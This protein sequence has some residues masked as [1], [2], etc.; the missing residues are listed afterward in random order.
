MIHKDQ[1]RRFFF[2]PPH[3]RNS[4]RTSEIIISYI[5]NIMKRQKPTIF[6]S[7]A[8]AGDKFLS[9]MESSS[10]SGSDNDEF[11]DCSAAIDAQ[12]MTNKRLDSVFALSN[13]FHS[14]ISPFGRN[15]QRTISAAESESLT[16]DLLQRDLDVYDADV[17]AFCQKYLAAHRGEHSKM[18][19][20]HAKLDQERIYSVPEFRPR[21]NLILTL[22]QKTALGRIVTAVEGVVV[23]ISIISVILE[24]FPQYSSDVVPSYQNAWVALEVAITTFFVL[25]TAFR[26]YVATSVKSV[27]KSF[28]NWC[29]VLSIL[30]LFVQLVAQ[31]RT[32]GWLK[33]LRMFRLVK[34]LRVF[35]YVDALAETLNRIAVSLIAPFVLL[36]VFIVVFGN[37][38][39]WVE[40]GSLFTDSALTDYLNTTNLSTA[41]TA[42]VMSLRNWAVQEDCL[43]TGTTAALFGNLT[44]LPVASKFISA[45]QGMWYATASFTTVGYGDITPLCAPG[46]AVT[47]LAMLFSTVFIAMPIAI[48][49]SSFTETVVDH[50]RKIMLNKRLKARN[51]RDLRRVAEERSAEALA[52][53]DGNGKGGKLK[54]YL[55]QSMTEK[56][57]ASA[58]DEQKQVS[59]A[60]AL[61]RFIAS[62]L[63]TEKLDFDASELEAAK[64]SGGDGGTLSGKCDDDDVL[65]SYA[66]STVDGGD[67]VTGVPTLTFSK[68]PLACR[69]RTELVDVADSFLAW[70]FEHW[71]H[72]WLAQGEETFHAAHSSN[73]F[74]A[75]SYDISSINPA[76]DF[77][78][79]VKKQQEMEELRSLRNDVRTKL[80]KLGSLHPITL[81]HANPR[82]PGVVKDAA[83]RTRCTTPVVGQSSNNLGDAKDFRWEPKSEKPVGAEDCGT[84]TLVLQSD[85]LW[86]PDT[87]GRFEL[88]NAFMTKKIYFTPHVSCVNHIEI[89]GTPLTE[90]AARQLLLEQAALT[91]I[92]SPATAP[93]MVVAHEAPIGNDS[94]SMH[95][96]TSPPSHEVKSAEDR[97]HQ[98]IAQKMQRI[99]AVADASTA[100]LTGAFYMNSCAGNI[101]GLAEWGPYN[102][103]GT[104][105]SSSTTVANGFSERVFTVQ[106]AE[107]DV[108]DFTPDLRLIE[109]VARPPRSLLPTVS[110][111]QHDPSTGAV[112]E[113]EM[114][115]N[116][117]RE[118]QNKRA[119]DLEKNGIR[120]ISYRVTVE[121][122]AVAREL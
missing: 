58:Q 87:I 46:K 33:T 15:A 60:E 73:P 17:F 52:G 19:S 102:V 39:Y 48:V 72:E 67:G 7:P 41:D 49:G 4:F 99:A 14:I 24:S 2:P 93:A 37:V 75:K 115:S 90:F 43:C 23:I 26:F 112:T 94:M 92:F 70:L 12:H 116:V 45:V 80:N 104:L 1:L 117:A 9:A 31:S 121:K 36:A 86:L 61:F 95:Y 34:L 40:G 18:S 74:A 103:H 25:V 16:V 82:K 65:S 35:Q 66:T 3:Q 114:S 53:A 71:L 5:R 10:S 122:G 85:E 22:N 64:N 76:K 79:T 62:Q 59:A 27:V 13:P 111:K 98:Q 51:I 63:R 106:L 11:D 50:H 83:I 91:K 81:F 113:F 32:Y 118:Q 119:V 8:R 101:L 42:K 120:R 68:L 110:R 78:K 47:S 108:I 29:D 109:E 38:M 21:W 97:K 105:Q 20:E 107:G 57:A 96:Q 77:A 84:G 44:C 100:S 56:P 6:T 28:M 88:V 30:P 89:N 55:S 54:R 69:Y